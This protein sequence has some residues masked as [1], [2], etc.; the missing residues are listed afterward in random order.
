MYN[1]NTFIID[2]NGTVYATGKNDFGQLGLGNLTEKTSFTKVNID[3]VQQISCGMYH[4]I[5][6]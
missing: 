2:K 1:N 3:N 4:T 5:I 6:I